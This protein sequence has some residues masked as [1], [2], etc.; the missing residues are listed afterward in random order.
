M[1][2]DQAA[3]SWTEHLRRG[4]TTTWAAWVAGAGAAVGAGDVVVPADWQAPGAAQL[5]LVRRL[6][7]R[8]AASP[9][10]VAGA[11]GRL[12]DVVL[13]R[14]AP[15]RGMAAAPLAWP[16]G[17]PAATRGLG[18]PPAD[19]ADVPP[20]EL[21]RVGVGV[22]AE[23][24]ARSPGPPARARQAR[25]RPLSRAFALCGAP[26]TTDA[27]RRS[28]AAAGQVEGGRS[29]QVVLLAEPLDAALAQVWSA[30]VQDGVPVRWRGFLDRWA[31]RVAEGTLPPA[32]DYPAMAALWA[33]QV[34]PE[35]V[36][37]VA[38]PAD[39]DTAAATTAAALGLPAPGRP[40]RCPTPQWQPLSAE[41]VD[42][43]RRVSAVLGVR[44][45]EREHRHAVRR[46]AGL[47]AQ[48]SQH[49]LAVPAP[50]R[51]WVERCAAEVATALGA[52]GYAVHGDLDR[53]V[54]DAGVGVPTG[55]RARA[56]L[57]LVLDACAR[58]AA[59][60]LLAGEAEP[61]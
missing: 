57:G 11:F 24:L 15:G 29:P 26:V 33:A 4:G 58:L 13:Q 1:R 9:L 25:R 39:P 54:P 53:L 28:L 21:V 61:R 23:L 6:A 2:R 50:H 44:V 47:L 43:L 22:L 32:V 46:L 16:A 45:A 37:V 12:A 55:P 40:G 42:V 14:S 31:R 48:R 56:E 18:A 36:H 7:G 10:L 19:P 41:G 30:R 38:A 17:P 49:R 35:R 27:V 5:E 59:L 52:G 34:G 60:E 20:A 51:P 8:P 3:W